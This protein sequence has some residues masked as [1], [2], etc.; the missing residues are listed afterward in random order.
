MDEGRRYRARPLR[1]QVR[2]WVLDLLGRERLRPGDRI[3]TEQ[4][5]VELL[6]VSRATLR[7][8]LQ[9][10]EQEGVI[11]SRH[12]KGRY[13]VAPPE[14]IAVDMTNLRSVTELL[15]EKGMRPTARVLEAKV[16]PAESGVAR[17]LQMAEGEPVLR[18]ERV[19]D[20][21]DV[22]VIYEIDIL[23]AER[24]ITPW[25]PEDFKSSLFEF[26]ERRW[27][28]RLAYSLTEVRSVSLDDSLAKRVGV[29]PE[30]PWILLEQVHFDGA[31][32]PVLY[33]RD[34]HRGDRIS[35]RVVRFRR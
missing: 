16:V 21:R 28:I 34:Y 33:S 35:F 1:Q 22:P 8:G 6:D 32:S 9:L 30:L 13:L 25:S 24:A 19:R 31:G 12:G 3:P 18:V 14:A 2:D 17:N 7:E 11:L 29:A 4:E 15:N 10:L 23:S 5:L 27:G 26:I 20:A